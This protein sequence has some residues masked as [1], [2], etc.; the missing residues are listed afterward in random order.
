[1]AN[2][3]PMSKH[4]LLVLGGVL[5]ALGVALGAFGAHAL[6]TSMSAMEDGAARLA[7]WHT[8]TQYHL[9]HALLVVALGVW[10]S[11][12]PGRFIHAAGAAAAV[13]IVL[14]SGSLYAMT[15][16]GVRALGAV[17]P[18]G[19]VAFLAAWVLVAVAARAQPQA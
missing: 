18:L 9:W 8:G 12:R 6:K 5:G 13:G 1:M 15:L 10:A 4:P 11:V 17:T 19:G 7:W 16:T 2:V 14:F 3:T